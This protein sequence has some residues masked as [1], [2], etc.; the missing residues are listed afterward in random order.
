MGGERG[1]DFLVEP[2]LAPRELLKGSGTV[3]DKQASDVTST[4]NEEKPGK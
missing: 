1:R 3:R 4:R 2:R